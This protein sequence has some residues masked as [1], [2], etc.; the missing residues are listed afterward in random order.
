MNSQKLN[1]ISS[2]L[3]SLNIIFLLLIF[4]KNLMKKLFSNTSFLSLANFNL[5]SFN[6]YG[7]FDK[8]V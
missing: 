5:Y 2:L 1:V 4:F 8:T 3:K 6:F 7:V